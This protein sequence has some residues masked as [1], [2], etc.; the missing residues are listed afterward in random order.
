MHFSKDYYDFCNLIIQSFDY[1]K[2][3]VGVKF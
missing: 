1:K 2:Q 3:E